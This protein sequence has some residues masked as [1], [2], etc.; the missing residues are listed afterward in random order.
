MLGFVCLLLLAMAGIGI[1]IPIFA[2]DNFGA[3]NE[4]IKE[5]EEEEEDLKL[6]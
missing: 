5:E 3:F 1:P 4:R 2:Q 6:V